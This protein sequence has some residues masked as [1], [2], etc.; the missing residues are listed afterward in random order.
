MVAPER[1]CLSGLVE[2]KE[3]YPG[4]IRLARVK[5]FSAKSLHGFLAAN[6]V[7]GATAKT[8]G[9]PGYNGATEVTHDPHVVLPSVH[10]VFSNLKTWALGVYHG[11][12]A[13]H[14]QTYLDEFTFRFNR[15]RNCRA[16]VVLS[17]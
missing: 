3:G 16:I 14:L 5:D 6:M 11:F 1:H 9:W 2:V 15:R 8:D 7:P 17:Q 13:Q 4:R 12:K 10:R